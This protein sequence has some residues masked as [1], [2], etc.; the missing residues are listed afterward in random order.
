MPNIPGSEAQVFVQ[1]SII[2]PYLGD[3]SWWEQY[4]PPYEKLDMASAAVIS[5]VE[6]VLSW[7]V[8][9]VKISS[10]PAAPPKLAVCI[11]FRTLV[12]STPLSIRWSV[13]FPTKIAIR[14]PATGGTSA[15]W[16]AEMRSR[17]YVC[18]KYEG[19]HASTLYS[20]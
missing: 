19:S 20:R 17:P 9:A 7:P 6:A 11:R 16:L 15:C 14:N 13:T 3:I 10:R 4:R 18:T 2:G 8:T 5:T 1:L 12:K